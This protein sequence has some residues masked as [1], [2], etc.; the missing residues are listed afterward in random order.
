M[1][2]VGAG[3]IAVVPAAPMRTRSRDTSHRYRP[4]SDFYYL[5]G[6]AEPEA[7]AVLMP[8]RADGEFLMFCRDRDPARE[9]WDGVRAGPAG[10]VERYGADDAFP[11]ADIDEILPGLLERSERVYYSMGS[12]GEFDQRLLGWLN[13]LN[14][15]RQSGHAPSELVAL[16][17]ALHEA[18]LF[19]SRAELSAMRR[20]ARVAVAA[21]RRAMSRCRPG[22][23]EFEL[24][25]E[26]LHEFRRHGGEPA[27]SPIVAGGANACILHYIENDQPLADGDLVLVDAG[28]ELDMYASDVTR[29][30]PVSGRFTERQ[31]D[32]Y[33]I[34][35]GAN[36]A[37]IGAVR[38]GNHWN[39]PHDVAVKEITRGLKALGIL[40]GR[41][42]TL[43]KE[44][45]Y[46]PF[47]MH[48]TGHWLGMDVHD[49]GDYKLSDAWRLLEP[50]MV[51]TVEPGIYIAADAKHVDRKWRGIGIRIED[52][53]A[54]TREGA[55][56]L[57]EGLP[58]TVDEVEACMSAA[59]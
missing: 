34:V 11:I 50:G 8:G 29:T 45:A 13:A 53:V 52:D 49:V 27:Y 40:R 39:D 59:A 25:A 26:Y 10:A 1:E 30:F 7:A 9:L 17:P 31:R 54:V 37:A 28:C 56:L 57:T 12:Y 18:R 20:S 55:E 41:L 51:L 15:R 3:G 42:P 35:L 6:F 21:H 33:E 44:Q 5:T 14:A 38:P 23:M 22:M 46:R 24:E 36:R 19:K 47:F 4:D 48:K 32:L 16:D 2:L 58:A 43:I